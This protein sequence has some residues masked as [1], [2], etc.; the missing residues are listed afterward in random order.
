VV[1]GR[2]RT[3]APRPHAVSGRPMLIYTYHAALCCGLERALAERH[4][5][6]MAWER[7]GRGMACVN[8]TWPPCVNQRAKT[9]SKPLAER[10]GMCELAFKKLIIVQLN[11]QCPTFYD[12]MQSKVH[13][14]DDKSCVESHVNR[15]RL[16][17]ISLKLHFNIRLP[18]SPCISTGIFLSG[19][20]N[21]IFKCLN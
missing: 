7:H 16:F 15:P 6:G 9:Q 4:I 3:R 11:K 14:C 5:L 20:S 10:H 19:F 21:E 13:Y 18:S 12:L 2:S 1:A 8:Q 17:I